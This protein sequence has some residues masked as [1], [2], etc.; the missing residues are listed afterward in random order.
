MPIYF[1]IIKLKGGINIEM[2]SLLKKKGILGLDTVKA[3]IIALLTLSVIAIA[4]FLALVSLQN[5]NIFTAGSNAANQT[6]NIINNVT[7]GT[8][9]FFA[10]VPTFFTLLGV[11]V[12]I[13]II[14]IVIVAVT[15][16]SP[17]A[18]RE[19]L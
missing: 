6:N 12:L 1:P 19:T 4:C 14:A 2:R 17:G 3:V 5:A 8:T 15:R 18:G 16:F 9:G 7:S 11:V 13:L 10:N